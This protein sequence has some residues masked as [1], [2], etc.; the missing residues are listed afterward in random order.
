[1][2]PALVTYE[3]EFEQVRSARTRHAPRSSPSSLNNHLFINGAEIANGRNL[4]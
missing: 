1:M 3:E 2:D 4:P